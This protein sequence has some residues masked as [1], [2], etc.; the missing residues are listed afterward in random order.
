MLRKQFHNF[1]TLFNTTTL[2]NSK[3]FLFIFFKS[4]SKV[5]EIGRKIH[6]I[7]KKKKNTENIQKNTTRKSLYFVPR[8]TSSCK[9]KKKKKKEDEHCDTFHSWPSKWA[10]N[11]PRCINEPV[12]KLPIRDYR[13]A[14][15]SSETKVENQSPRSSI[16]FSHELR[17]RDHASDY[18]ESR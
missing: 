16:H 3:L 1:L 2:N 10:S 12:I 4:Y 17:G 5:I 14:T 15:R 18:V 9:E 8:L 6:C 13:F 11:F 7:S